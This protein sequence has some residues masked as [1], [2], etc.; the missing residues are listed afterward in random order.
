[1]QIFPYV[2]PLQV[3]NIFDEVLHALRTGLFHLFRDMAV[4]VKGEAGRGVAEIP[5]HRL[6]M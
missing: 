1:M 3:Q 6:Y 4:N 5:L 2:F